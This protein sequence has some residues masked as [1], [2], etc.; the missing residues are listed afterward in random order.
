VSLH[1]QK[2]LP[3]ARRGSPLTND[4]GVVATWWEHGLG[5]RKTNKRIN[6]SIIAARTYIDGLQSY[7][8]H[9]PAIDS[10]RTCVGTIKSCKAS[11]AIRSV[12]TNVFRRLDCRLVR[13]RAEAG[14]SSY[15]VSTL[16]GEYDVRNDY[17]TRTHRL[18]TSVAERPL[19]IYLSCSLCSSGERETSLKTLCPPPDRWWSRERLMSG[20]RIWLLVRIQGCDC[21]LEGGASVNLRVVSS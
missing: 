7:V 5:Q 2:C 18:Q 19:P 6:D 16:F 3:P 9:Y 12:E 10:S 15:Y 8:F 17:W 11:S 14:A 4:T 21:A 13:C 20:T 1:G